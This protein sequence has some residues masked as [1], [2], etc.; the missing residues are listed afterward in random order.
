MTQLT[1]NVKTHVIITFSGSHHFIN[2]TQEKRL[3]SLS[4]DDQIEI[5]GNTIFIKSI[6]EI[7]TVNK[8]Y[9][10]F[11]DRKEQDTAYTA[12]PKHYETLINRIHKEGEAFKGLLKGLKRFCDGNPKSLKANKFY[13]EQLKKY[14][15]KYEERNKTANKANL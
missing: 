13:Q 5:D 7:I 8:Y 4:K 1:T 6:S 2:A 11:P 9:Q 14:N 15:L 10:T 3:Q 12:K